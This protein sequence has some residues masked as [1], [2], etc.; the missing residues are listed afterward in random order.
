MSDTTKDSNSLEFDAIRIGKDNNFASDTD[1]THK[2]RQLLHQTKNADTD[3]D[4]MMFI[5]DLTN[6]AIGEV[7]DRLDDAVDITSDDATAY[8]E[9]LAAIE[10]E[11]KLLNDK[12]VN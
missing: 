9:I 4:A 1:V 7:L 10:A 6:K 2:L 12:E 5:K 3:Y 8:G 11:L